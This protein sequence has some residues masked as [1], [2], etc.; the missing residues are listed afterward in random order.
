MKETDVIDLVK[1]QIEILPTWRK[2]QKLQSKIKTRKKNINKANK[3]ITDLLVE[4]A[5]LRTGA[6]VKAL[7]FFNG[8][9][10]IQYVIVDIDP[11]DEHDCFI[12][13]VRAE[14]DKIMNNRLF[15][16]D[17][18]T[19]KRDYTIF[20]QFDGIIPDFFYKHINRKKND[21]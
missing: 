19:F 1:E 20:D 4:I 17:L 8:D 21:L 12:Y 2:V 7:F 3:E 11:V 14:N 6:Y 18:K 16:F 9:K 13:A 5:E 15:H 10:K